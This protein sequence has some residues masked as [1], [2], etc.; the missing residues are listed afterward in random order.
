MYVFGSKILH[1]W[2]MV[3]T[4]TIFSVRHSHKMKSFHLKTIT[5][6]I[7]SSCFVIS[8]TVHAPSVTYANSVIFGGYISCLN[9][10]LLRQTSENNTS[11]WIIYWHLRVYLRFLI[12]Q[13]SSCVA[14]SNC[15]QMFWKE[16]ASFKYFIGGF[17]FPTDRFAFAENFSLKISR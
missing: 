4:R 6:R 13:N 7:R 8:S 14:H 3:W 17:A 5:W 2:H 11:L 10:K 9:K 15:Y 12:K 16:Q 1:H